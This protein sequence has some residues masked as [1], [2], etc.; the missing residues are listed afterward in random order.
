L[1]FRKWR[2][3]SQRVPETSI[4]S[5]VGIS[6][7]LGQGQHT[8]YNLRAL[9]GFNYTIVCV[10]L[11]Q[12]H[13]LAL[14]KSGEVLSWGLNRFHQLG[15]VVETISTPGRLDEPI[16]SVPRKVY[17]ALK[18]E[19]VRGVAAC[20]IASAC[21][22]D[23]EVFT[24]G[25]NNGQLGYDKTAQPIQILPRKVTKVSQPVVAL[26]ASVRM[27]S[28]PYVLKW[29]CLLF[30]PLRIMPLLVFSTPEKFSASGMIDIS[31]SSNVDPF[32]FMHRIL[33]IIL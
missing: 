2:A 14:T 23:K 32:P 30:F 8:Q 25:T 31:R 22:T 5:S 17:G 24:W 6:F 27:P 19:Q 9:A 29:L 16:Q 12:D 7:S 13:T 28:D 18:K 15:Y 1:W 10:A 20:K 33:I 4:H 11:G 3:V 21:W 26:A